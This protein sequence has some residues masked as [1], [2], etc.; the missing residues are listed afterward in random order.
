MKI[1]CSLLAACALGV[2]ATIAF[3]K[4]RD[5]PQEEDWDDGEDWDDDDGWNKHNSRYAETQSP[6]EVF[7]MDDLYGYTN[8][9]PSLDYMDDEYDGIDD[10]DLSWD[11]PTGKDANGNYVSDDDDGFLLIPND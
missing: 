11:I 9:R 10:H 6:G 3:T 2:V 8:P 5:R 1:I 4:L 7:D